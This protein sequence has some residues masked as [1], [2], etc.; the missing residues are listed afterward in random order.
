MLISKQVLI[1]WNAKIKN[2]YV[3]LGYQFT[4]MGEEFCVNVEDLTK[5]SN[6]KVVV[7]CDYCHKQF[8]KAWHR[9]IQENQDCTIHKDCCNC[10]KK[11]KIQETAEKKYG[12]S[13]V[14]KL[15]VIQ[16]K[17][18]QTNLDKYGVINP[19]MSDEIKEKIAESNIKKYGFRSPM[20]NPEILKKTSNTCLERYGVQYYI[21]TQCFSGAD[22]PV[23]KGGVAV[24]RN[25]RVTY[26]YIS[27]RK[28]VFG[29]DSYTCQCC[30]K[31][32]KTGMPITLNAHHIKN[33]KDNPNERYCVN[34]GITL[35]EDCH[36]LFHQL[37]GKRNNNKE[38]IVAFIN[39]Y[40]KKIC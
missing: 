17:I 39:D 23:W 4:K 33:W 8:E 2:H 13:T 19:F 6:V 26:E 15:P 40:G 34:N 29:R 27:W 24:Q 35:C 12:V 31:K 3:D 18:K 37:Y 32:S 14:L 25:E 20:Q 30:G 16:N 22:S 9:Y 1:R 10:C 7:E 11:H 5:G 38:Q 21:Q 36:L 28:N